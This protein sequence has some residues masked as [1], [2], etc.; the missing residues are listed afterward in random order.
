MK[1]YY[2]IALFAVL[3]AAAQTRQFSFGVKGGVPAQTPLG[4]TESQM[5]FVLGADVEIRM[6][7]GLSLETGVLFDRMGQK[8][9]SF[10]F[11]YPENAVTLLYSMGRGRAIELPFLAKYRFRSE[12]HNWRPYVS[13]GP[14]VRRTSLTASQ[15]TSILSG[16]SSVATVGQVVPESNS[17]KWNAD[18]T[19]AAGVDFKAGRVHL[20]PEVRY[21]YWGAGK[22]WPV[23]KHQVYF[24]LGFRF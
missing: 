22:N 17:V 12:S 6:Y 20:E 14:T 4:Q 15:F 21:S 8:A 18:P 2:L 11:Q 23:R 3:P 7:S 1:T 24:L 13:A 19:A 5:P 9:N 16:S 10:A